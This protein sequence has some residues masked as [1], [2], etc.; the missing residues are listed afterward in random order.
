M[1]LIKR[2]EGERER[3]QGDKKRLDEIT[4][5]NKGNYNYGPEENG[6]KES[7]KAKRA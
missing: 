6:E 7:N 4:T 5:T 2:R 1:Y 3:E